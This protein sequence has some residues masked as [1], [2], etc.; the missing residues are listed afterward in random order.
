MR[1]G[2][3]ASASDAHETSEI[4]MSEISRCQ[5]DSAGINYVL[6]LGNKYGYRPFPAK[7]PQ[8]EFDTLLTKVEPEEAELAKSWYQL[9]TNATPATYILKPLSEDTKK[10][11][12]GGDFAKLQS[13]FRTAAAALEPERRVLYEQSVTA[14]EI[15]RG[16]L[17]LDEQKRGAKAFVFDRTIED[18]PVD[19]DK[20]RLFKDM[21][22]GA[23][24]SDAQGRLEQ[25][26]VDIL[27]KALPSDRIVKM[28][29]PWGPGIDSK[30]EKH[31]AYLAQFS[32]K[33]CEVVSESIIQIAKDTT[34]EE[35]AL[36]L[37][38]A[39]HA[40]FASERQATFISTPATEVVAQRVVKLTDHATGD[41]QQ[42]TH[43]GRARRWWFCCCRGP[44][45]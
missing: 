2:I 11:W 44:I 32:D 45:W 30:L 35:D 43:Y 29:L 20:A 18:I 33:F 24:D 25:L 26:R 13:T 12:W 10:T 21:A 7:I 36:V 40:T 37:E 4:C 41:H 16:L 1:W 34:V 23:V 38:A 14:E 5:K 8:T 27:P 42:H 22:D 9:D 15:A 6:I 28:S 39:S 31:S 3:Q 19:D 17:D